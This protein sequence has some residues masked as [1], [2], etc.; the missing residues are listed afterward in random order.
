MGRSFK[1]PPR[2]DIEQWRKVEALWA[3]GFRFF[4]YRTYPDAEPLPE[5]FKDVA[6]FV[7]RNPNH[8][9]RVRQPIS[10]FGG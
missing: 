9:F 6:S 3:A 4:S 5:R 1:A 7:Q 10:S 8:P 2:S